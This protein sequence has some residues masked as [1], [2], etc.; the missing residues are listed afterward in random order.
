MKSGDAGRRGVV[1]L[2]ARI[3]SIKFDGQISSDEDGRVHVGVGMG[4]TW[5]SC[6]AKVGVF[7][8]R[9]GVGF[10]SIEADVVVC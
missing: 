10:Q 1:C 7:V 9:S 8:C 4:T 2:M 3:N 5:G 6:G